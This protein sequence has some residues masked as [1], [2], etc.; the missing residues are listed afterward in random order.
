MLYTKR[1]ITRVNYNMSDT[2]KESIE[3]MLDKEF[4]KSYRKAKGQIEKRIFADWGNL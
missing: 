4:M 1:G 3:L 2:R